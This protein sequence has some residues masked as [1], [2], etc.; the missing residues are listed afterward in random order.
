MENVAVNYN[1]TDITLL[2]ELLVAITDNDLMDL[3]IKRTLPNN[4]G[5]QYRN[6]LADILNYADICRAEGVKIYAR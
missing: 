1:N 2:D 4:Y 6:V 3:L 5:E